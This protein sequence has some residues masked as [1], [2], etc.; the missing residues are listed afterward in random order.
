MIVESVGDDYQVIGYKYRKRKG[1]KIVL[2]GKGQTF[3]RR[4]SEREQYV[5]ARGKGYELPL[6]SRVSHSFSGWAY[7]PGVSAWFLP[8]SPSVPQNYSY[9]A[10]FLA[11]AIICIFCIHISGVSEN[12]G[13]SLQKRS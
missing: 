11:E 5:G 10:S 4:M 9:K 8:S 1:L 12:N 6:Y 2:S 3:K 7:L 13:W